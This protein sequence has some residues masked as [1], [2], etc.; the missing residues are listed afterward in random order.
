VLQL[1]VDEAV[2]AA[3]PLPEPAPQPT[4]LPHGR[5]LFGL[6]RQGVSR[7]EQGASPLFPTDPGPMA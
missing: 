7:A 3:R 4:W 1:E 6:F 5:Q 2:L